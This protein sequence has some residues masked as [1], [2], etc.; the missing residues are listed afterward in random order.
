MLNLAVPGFA[1]FDCCVR[2]LATGRFIVCTD[3]TL[4]TAGG[5]VRADWPGRAILKPLVFGPSF[6]AAVSDALQSPDNWQINWLLDCW[7][8]GPDCAADGVANAIPPASS[9]MNLFILSTPFCGLIYES[10]GMF[11]N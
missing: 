10:L 4:A 8:T 1:P 2:T 6:V 11:V 3:G 5:A 7:A 9:K